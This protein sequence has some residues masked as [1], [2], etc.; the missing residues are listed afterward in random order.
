V[1]KKEV[2]NSKIKYE[3][4]AVNKTAMAFKAVKMG[5]SGI[6]T[7]GKAGLFAIKAMGAAAIAAAASIALLTKKSF[8]YID[9]LG[10]TASRT[11]IATETLQA[12]QLA[13]IE[14]G[15]TVE[16]TQKGLEK[17]A[18]S[19]GDAGRGLKTQVDI[20]SD[21]GVTLKN[22]DGSLKSF[23]TI[24]EGVAEG[25]GELGSEAERATALA[26]L[27]GRAGIQF[28]E[29]FRDGA[30]GLEEFTRRANDLGII[31]DDKTIRGVEQFNDT[32]SVVKLQVGAV[33]NNITAAFVPALQFL[34]EELKNVIKDSKNTAEGF[35]TMGQ[36]I[37]VSI[38]EGVK[39]ALIAMQTFFTNVRAMFIDFAS[40]GIGKLMFGDI[41][42]ETDKTLL[43][44]KKF[45]D[46]IDD[47]RKNGF[48][49]GGDIIP[50]GMPAAM[51]ELIRLGDIVRRLKAS[52]ADPID[53]EG[54]FVG[55]IDN[56]IDLV[57]AGSPEVEKLFETFDSGLTNLLEPVAAFEKSLGA[58]GLAKTLETTAVS[59]MKKFEDSIVD[60]LKAGK[61]SFKNFADYV[62][63]QLLR[64]A[65]QQMIL[66][67]ITG[68]FE[69]FFEGFGDIFSA[70]GGG[71]T[72][73]GIRAGGVDGKG[74]FPA[75]LHPNETVVDH[76]KGQGMTA[77]PTVNFNISTVDAAGFDQLLASR[78]GL[79][80][81][82]I[83]N[84]MNNQGKMGIV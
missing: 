52:I 81:S 17:F 73:S 50:P 22:T 68:K 77:S 33:V 59:S 23:E 71:Y 3:I 49:I 15:T 69:S 27:F 82:I 38:L 7:A 4:I 42:S 48:A 1:R 40:T 76:T 32:M 46:R 74:G 54:G 18:R 30:D 62:V 31:L 5:L 11:G 20:F 83:N 80:T 26:N 13:A 56:L 47:I 28:S 65:I 53:A 78:K 57:K 67:P 43:Q 12:F 37:A 29:I 24:L 8:D 14:S 55:T 66:K 6:A 72:G 19:I 58:E 10:K 60:S 41:L 39:T 64:I 51:D 79:I 75:I 84:A 70:D 2:A 16:Q 36:L 61:L 44:I 21:L 34:A 9:T 45:E 25:L 35:D 63:E